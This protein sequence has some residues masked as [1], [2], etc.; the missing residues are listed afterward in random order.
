MLPNPKYILSSTGNKYCYYDTGK[1]RYTIIAFTC[2]GASKATFLP[3]IKLLPNVRFIVFDY[4]G[5]SGQSFIP[6]QKTNIK[7]HTRLA[8]DFLKTLKVKDTYTFLGYSYGGLIVS[9]L[10]K[11]YGYKP[12]N[13]IMVSPVKS[14]KGT[15]Q[16]RKS[17][18]QFVIKV[19]K[20]LPFYIKHKIV[21][22][23]FKNELASLKKYNFQAAKILSKDIPTNK[24][25]NN[26]ILEVIA[27][28]ENIGLNKKTLAKYKTLVIQGNVEEKTLL[29]Q[30][31]KFFNYKN[32]RIVVIK[33]GHNHIV[34]N[35][36]ASVESIK[37]FIK[38]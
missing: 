38:S 36:R 7:L 37:E 30:T 14:I 1:G 23:K 18:E 11:K 27:K 33:G 31:K 3:L 29:K 28:P 19:L 2:W 35:P 9:W 4:P 12:K 16:A 32:S 24:D 5:W 15:L 21:Y 25:V 20:Y 34:F 26:N 8:N 17:Y 22:I 10:I 6:K 13:L